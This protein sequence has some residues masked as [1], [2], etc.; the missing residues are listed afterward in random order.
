MPRV[1]RYKKSGRS[2][3]K[4]SRR[5]TVRSRKT[6]RKKAPRWSNRRAVVPRIWRPTTIRNLLPARLNVR[7]P[8]FEN[9]Q[10]IDETA[11]V[12]YMEAVY[13]L[14]SCF[15]PNAFSG[16]AAHQ[17][18]MFDQWATRYNRYIVRGC[19]YT[20]DIYAASD[21]SL[22]TAAVNLTV[23]TVAAPEGMYANF[24]NLTDLMEWPKDKNIKVRN[25]TRNNGMSLAATSPWAS[26]R[27]RCAGY[28]N[29]YEQYKQWR[30][31]DLSSAA[32]NFD[33]PQDYSAVVTA[34]PACEVQ[35]TCFAQSL[36]SDDVAVLILPNLYANVRL[37]Y[38]V[39]FYDPIYPSAS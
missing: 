9:A 25:V 8:Y 11:A 6:Y 16:S 17:P 1:S 39:E 14:N 24:S 27:S 15:A 23:G 3:K 34:T 20:I 28:V 12:D 35:L 2:Y 38:D 37:V 4:S 5:S 7:L 31:V 19:S 32:A 13:R 29:M 18:R 33:W 30:G 10:L 21:A 26:K 22:T 36:N